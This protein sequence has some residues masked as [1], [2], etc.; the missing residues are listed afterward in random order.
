[1]ERLADWAPRCRPLG[2]AIQSARLGLA[3]RGVSLEICVVI[4]TYNEAQNLPQLVAELFSLGLEDLHALVVDDSSPDGT[5]ELA[6]EL[7]RNLGGRLHV[8]RRPGK[9]GLGRAYIA[10]FRWAL[11]RQAR[12]IAQMDADLSHPPQK[13]PALLEATRE[14]DVAVGS[15][16]VAGGSTDR[17]W[18]PW[19]R[20]LSLFANAY[21]RLILGLQVRDATAG[22]K[23][24]RPE[25]LEAID[26]EHLSS[27]G[28]IFQ[29]EVAY[30]CELLGFRVREVPIHF[31]ERRTGRSKM[32]MPVKLEAALRIWQIRWRYRHLGHSR[33]RG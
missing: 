8:L 29:V 1:M 26:L 16:Y 15:R 20:G 25:V 18:S 14:C 32:S 11:E 21:A 7:A 27:T 3:W 12:R 23:C 10:G 2:G 24:F 17:L 33:Q 4:P 5:G 31:A 13:L 9:Q 6:L 19:R 22:F 28:Y 30:L